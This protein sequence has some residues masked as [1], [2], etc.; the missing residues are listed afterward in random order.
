VASLSVGFDGEGDY[1]QYHSIYDSIDHYLRFMDPDFSHGAALSKV[2]ARLTLRLA[3][4]DVLPFEFGRFATTVSGYVGEVEKLADSMRTETTEHN[5]RVENGEFEAVADPRYASVPPKAREPVPFLN[6]AP[7]RNAAARI[8]AAAA[9]YDGGVG[10]AIAGGWL[11]AGTRQALDAVLMGMERRLT[12][13]HGLPGRPWFKHFVYAPG[14]YTG[15]GVKTLPTVR[16]AIEQRHWDEVDGAVAATA[17][18][19]NAYAS[20]L[21]RAA[22]MVLITKPT[23]P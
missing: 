21:E 17:A 7:L 18:A 19:L 3:N 2:N 4:A 11:D 8:Q 10:P 12:R 23:A 20:E 9:K 5:L 22:G 1:G 16:E 15:Y 6:F 13:D 14:L